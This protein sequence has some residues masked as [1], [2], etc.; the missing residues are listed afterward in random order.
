MSDRKPGEPADRC[1]LTNTLAGRS[2]GNRPIR[3]LSTAPLPVDPPMAMMSLVAIAGMTLPQAN[4]TG[5]YPGR[6]QPATP[7][8]R[9]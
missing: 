9:A 2:W 8:I 6:F 7:M 3:V 5:R 1:V 4:P